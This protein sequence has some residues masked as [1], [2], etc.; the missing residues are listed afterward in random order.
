[1]VQMTRLEANPSM[2]SALKQG[3]EYSKAEEEHDH[4]VSG[5]SEDDDE[6]D[7][8]DGSA[9]DDYDDDDDSSISDDEDGESV[10]M[11][12]LERWARN[13]LAGTSGSKVTGKI[14]RNNSSPAISALFIPDTARGQP[15][16][17]SEESFMKRSDSAP[18]LGGL[19]PASLLARMQ[20]A[21]TVGLD[22]MMRAKRDGA[23]KKP[24]KSPQDHLNRILK[25]KGVDPKRAKA[26]DLLGT[27]FLKMSDENIK[28][29][30]FR[31]A[32]AVRTGD[33]DTLREIH[34]QG[35]L[36]QCCNQYK[37][38][39]VHTA[40]RRGSVDVVRFLIKEAGV[41]LRVID[42]YGR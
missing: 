6:V 21:E 18:A 15:A 16:Q 27:F 36:M 34:Q 32:R 24:K 23:P 29:Y 28:A 10:A 35:S 13:T 20:A 17:Q 33:I 3:K 25:D 37:E 22:T 9:D 2:E 14:H 8:S 39:I 40:C 30:D 4:E 7:D 38:S 41:S 26:L 12:E 42:D 31:K 11:D 19:M 1:M 5:D